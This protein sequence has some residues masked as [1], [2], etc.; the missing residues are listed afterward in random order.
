[1]S[2]TTISTVVLEAGLFD[3]LSVVHIHWF[4][5]VGSKSRWW[6]KEAGSS[7]HPSCALTRG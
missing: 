5:E 3:T 1:M 4:C 6:P 2:D 7:L